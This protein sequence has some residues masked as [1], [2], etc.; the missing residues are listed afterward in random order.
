MIPKNFNTLFIAMG[1]GNKNN[2]FRRIEILIHTFAGMKT[3]GVMQKIS[4]WRL[5]L[6]LSS[7]NFFLVLCAVVGV[8]AGL[9]AVALKQATG[10][11]ESLFKVYEKSGNF[12]L[13]ISPVIGILL[14]TTYTW[15][16]RKGKLG[17]GISNLIESINN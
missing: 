16:F 4:Q 14:A 15:I 5:K 7:N 13:L 10:E 12:V 2:N 6:K 8:V 17:R 9:A 1:F 3:G 11:L